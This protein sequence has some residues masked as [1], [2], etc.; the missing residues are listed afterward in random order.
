MNEK[1]NEKYITDATPSYGEPQ[2]NSKSYRKD[3]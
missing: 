2:V 3:F 1:S